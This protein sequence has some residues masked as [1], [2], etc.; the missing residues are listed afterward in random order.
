MSGQHPL[1]EYIRKSGNSLTAVAKDAK[2]SRMTLYRL[3]KGELNAT[4][5]LLMRVSAATGGKV[6]VSAFKLQRDRVES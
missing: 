3:T 6:P 2:C 4:M 5:D 1:F